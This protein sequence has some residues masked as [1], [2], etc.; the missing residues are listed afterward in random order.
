LHPAS[1]VRRRA[2]SH[3]CRSNQPALLVKKEP[4]R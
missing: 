2:D 1:G 3:F 4:S